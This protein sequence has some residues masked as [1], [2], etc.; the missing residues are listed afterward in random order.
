MKHGELCLLLLLLWVARRGHPCFHCD[1][2]LAQRLSRLRGRIKTVK[3]IYEGQRAWY[4]AQFDQAFQNS[5]DTGLIDEYN[6]KDLLQPVKSDLKRTENTVLKGYPLANL[7]TWRIQHNVKTFMEER[8]KI[9]ICENECGTLKL[10]LLNCTTCKTQKHI[11]KKKSL[12]HDRNISVSEFDSLRLDCSEPWH[13]KVQ[14]KGLFTFNVDLAEAGSPRTYLFASESPYLVINGITLEHQGTYHCQLTDRDGDIVSE[15]RFEVNVHSVQTTKRPV[16]MV[17]TL[18]PV[19]ILL[20][21]ITPPEVIPAVIKWT[22]L[23]LAIGTPIMIS[24]ICYCCIWN[25]WKKNAEREG[26]L[27]EM[28]EFL[29]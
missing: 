10:N 15:K 27:N 16:E 21:T 2:T 17:P 4:L 11:C 7:I 19:N 26:E 25:A 14:N 6:L 18:P 24:F 22:V 20:A 5:I 3:D 28:E 13:F 12:C 29:D 8:E 1:R 9:V 23:I